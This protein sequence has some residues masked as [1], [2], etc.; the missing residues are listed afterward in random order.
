VNPL[1][2]FLIRAALSLIVAIGAVIVCLILSWQ[3]NPKSVAFL[4][5][6]FV[7][8]WLISPSSEKWATLNAIINDRD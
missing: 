2:A 7:L 1:T 8:S 3:G 5:L 6:G 4:I